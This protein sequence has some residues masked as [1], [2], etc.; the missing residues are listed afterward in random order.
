[1][2]DKGLEQDPGQKFGANFFSE[3]T[4]VIAQKIEQLQ[5]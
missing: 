1:V 2:A 3:N 5:R 4:L